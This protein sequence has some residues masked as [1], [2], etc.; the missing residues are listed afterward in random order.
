MPKG[1]HRFGREAVHLLQFAQVV[2]VIHRFVSVEVGVEGR[3]ENQS[4]FAP[5]ETEEQR[6][7]ARAQVAASWMN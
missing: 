7:V 4:L 5:N 1:F 6:R 3:S 2:L